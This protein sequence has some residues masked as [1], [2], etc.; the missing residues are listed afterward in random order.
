MEK[1]TSGLE[2]VNVSKRNFRKTL[3]S[4]QESA[5]SVLL[6]T[7]QWKEIESYFD[8]TR[9]VLDERAKELDLLEES[10]KVRALELEKKEKEVFSKQS[11]LEKKEKEFDLEKKEKEF[12]LEKKEKEL[13]LLEESIKVRALEL[14]KKEKEVFSKQSDFEKKEKEFD[15]EK[16]AEVE[17]KKGE[18]E[19]L[20]KFTTR[21]ESVERFSDEKLMEL[22][23]RAKELELK[24]KEVEEQREQSIAGEDKFRGEF[25]P[26]VSLL[27]KNMGS[28]VTMPTKCSALYLNDNAKEFADDLVKK[29]TGLARMVPYLDPAKFVLDAIDETF[30]EYLNKD[31]GEAGDRVD[32]VVKSCI[33]MLDTL[34]KMNLKMTTKVKEEAT[35]LGVVWIAKAKTNQNNSSM[36]LGCLL[37]LAAYSLASLTTREV[38]FTL[39]ERFLSY[40]QAPKLFRLLGLE[41]KVSGVVETLKKREDYLTTLKFICE[42]RLY[43]LC[44]AGRPGEFLLDFLISSDKAARVIAGT[45]NSIEAQKARREKRRA[46]AV[47]ALK[48][49]KEAKAESMFP[50][51]IL[52]KLT[53]LKNDESVQKAMEPVRKS[54]EKGQSTTKAVGKPDAQSISPHEHNTA[55]KRQRLTEPIAPPQNSTVKRVE[56][57]SI[58]SGNQIKESGVNHQPDTIATHPS[59]TETK[60]N[61]L[62]SFITADMLRELVNKQPLNESE[63][64]SNALKCTPD[65]AKIFLDTSM[66]LCATNAEG[67]YEFKLLVTSASCSVLL[68][69]LK[70]LM[71]QIGHPVKGD[72]KKLA[73]YWKDKIL[74]CKRDELEVICFLQFLGIFGI[75]SEFKA[76]DLL[77]L[78]DNSYWQSVSPDLCQFLGLDNAMPG[79]IQ[80]L[81]KT[82]HR[83]KAVD[84][85]YSFG[86]VHRFQPV[87]AIINDS[88][89]ITKESAEKSYRDA[90]N[91]SATQVAAIDRQIRTLRAAIKCIKC[92]KLESEFQLE[93]L[94]EQIKSLLK[95]RRNTTN[96]GSPS[97]PDL[98]IQQSQTEIPPNVTAEVAS[99]TRNTPLEPSIQ[100]ASSCA[101]KPSSAKK[102]KRGKKR[103]LSGNNQNSGHVASHTS[104][105]FPSH[106]YSLNQRQTWPVDNYDRGF[107]GIPNS[108]YHYNP[109]RQQP[110]EPQVYQVYQPLNPFYRRY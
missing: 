90:K 30:K 98:T 21:I 42:F 79:F 68:N 29:N 26:L 1:V 40:D 60:P 83:I 11:D 70:K 86:M 8:S 20:E 96:N 67:G 61:V 36:G 81:I 89:R 28:S 41:N 16:K 76:N 23:V 48:Y 52:K 44:P 84:Y 32:S 85:I 15:L 39:L 73:I 27:A 34:I 49:I 91:E 58:P 93:N 94:E 102:N 43:K 54:Y 62:P 69:Q 78:L 110:E 56:V 65:P 71:P 51:K 101:S 24:V 100:A 99:G 50:A 25:E 13:D 82:G 80:N 18:V 107:T 53:A 22:D 72:A 19:Q 64:L 109:W 45:G 7:I 103:S 46:D 2:L 31:L 106:D 105:H 6:L 66:A 57:V 87:S 88:L 59:S 14:E 5:H 104:N 74:K 47:M 12:D 33:D 10:I 17:K 38:L 37:F 77:G 63:D 95:L 108:E 92:H 4:I 55:A 3:E 35:Q 75:V 9:S 97:K